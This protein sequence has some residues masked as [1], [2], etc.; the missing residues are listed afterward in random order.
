MQKAK[1]IFIAL[2]TVLI[3]LVVAGCYRHKTPEQKAERVVQ[4][5]VSDLNL[6]ANQTAK[7][8]KIKEEFL[9]RG[10]EM[11]KMREDSFQDIKEMLV[12]PELDQAR[13]AKRTEKIQRQAND[14]IG[15]VAAKFAELHDMLTPEQRSKL[16][17]EMEK[18][19]HQTYHW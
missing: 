3:A 6:N 5:L 17:D 8:E 16:A 2:L 12:S 7:L 11:A 15:F 14:L 18:H 1:Y 10:Q 4:Y 13:F 9:A 19:S